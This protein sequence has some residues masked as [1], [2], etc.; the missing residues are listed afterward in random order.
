MEYII[1]NRT[2]SS[3]TSYLQLQTIR[4]FSTNLTAQVTSACMA[5]I[6]L[7]TSNL[8]GCHTCNL[9][10]CHNNPDMACVQSWAPHRVAHFHMQGNESLLMGAMYKGEAA[11]QEQ[12]ERQLLCQSRGAPSKLARVL[13]VVQVFAL[14]VAELLVQFVA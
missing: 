6:V 5:D 10:G 14:L 8:R 2:L 4:K 7:D 13:M 11:A 12:E 1:E 3:E 9:R